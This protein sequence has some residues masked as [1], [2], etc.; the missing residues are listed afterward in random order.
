MQGQGDGLDTVL[1]SPETHKN[2]ARLGSVTYVRL[3]AK[4][5]CVNLTSSNFCS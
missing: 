5:L 4:Q 1:I 2:G 3:T